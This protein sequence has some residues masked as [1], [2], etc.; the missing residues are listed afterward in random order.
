VTCSG[1]VIVWLG[2]GAFPETASWLAQ[3]PDTVVVTDRGVWD[4]AVAGWLAAH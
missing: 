2:A 4:A 3:C 1:N